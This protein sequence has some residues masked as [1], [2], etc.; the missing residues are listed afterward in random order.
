M[1][2]ILTFLITLMVLM[3]SVVAFNMPHPIYGKITDDGI[4]VVGLSVRVK[5]LDT[6]AEG[7]ATTNLAGFYQVDLGNIDARYNDG[8]RIVSS[9]VFCEEL[10]KCK[11]ENVVSGGGNE[12]SFDISGMD[13]PTQYVCSDGSVVSDA[14]DCPVIEDPVVVDKPSSNEDKT[15]VSLDLFYGDSVDIILGNNKLSKLLD[16]KIRF[17]DEN[18]DVREEVK[19]SGQI[20]TSM[21]DVDFRLEP[22]FVVNTIS[23]NLIFKDLIDLSDI[24]EEETLEITFLG[25]DLEIS[26]ARND[27]IT[28]LKGVEYDVL[29]GET[30]DIGM[31]ITVIGDDF[32]RVTYQGEVETIHTGD[33]EYVG[34]LQVYV[35]EAMSDEDVT[36]FATI[37]VGEDV[38][39][40]IEDGDDYNDL[41]EWVIDL[42]NSIGVVNNNPFEDL[43]DN[44]RPLAEG[45][46]LALPND[47]VK[48]KFSATHPE[49]YDLDIRVKNEYLLVQGEF[50]FGT[51][52]YDELY[53]KADGI[54]DE[55]YELITTDSVQIGDS[56]VDLEL[57]SLTIGKIKVLLDMSDILY[58]GISFA[59]KDDDFLDYFGLIFRDP[60]DAV[61][62]QRDLEISVPEERPEVT[63]LIGDVS[64][65]EETTCQVVDREPCP[66]CEDSTCIVIEDP[67]VCP[68]VPVCDTCPEPTDEGN[69][70]LVLITG[71]ITLGVGGVGGYF[72]K[73]KEALSKGIG[74]KIYTKRDGT[75]NVLHK[76]PGIT[77]YHEPNTSHR[78]VNEKHP[79]G[80]LTPKFE[81]DVDGIWKY[82]K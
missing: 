54:Y 25:L 44:E 73:R 78:D 47:Y 21:D 82:V 32:I 27:E 55:D 22:Y 6:G 74:I 57:G 52:E 11:V 68:E 17:D 48:V 38:R 33:T 35:K 81:K 12:L 51:E 69:M 45:E 39:E 18:Y 71:L 64:E 60:Q 58:D 10:D 59:S 14:A 8:D 42:P 26:D 63:I 80:E 28:L 36:D 2:K 1:K 23:Y 76:H 62:D 9:L 7:L 56:D 37:L 29:E 70:W 67:K 24:T 13:Y 4:P 34:D 5:N 72:V 30:I 61:D 65:V 50:N 43:E 79:R 20:Q 40:T 41:F 31:E 53:I 66:T 75:E 19:L 15:Q 16:S 49:M 46:V 77:G 3:M